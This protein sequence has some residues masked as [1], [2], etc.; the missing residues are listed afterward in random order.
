M[1]RPE[2]AQLSSENTSHYRFIL[3]AP[4]PVELPLGL[5]KGNLIFA[6][7]DRCAFVNPMFGSHLDG[8][9]SCSNFQA[10]S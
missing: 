6:L 3:R 2:D 8:P 5:R 4:I 10:V 9:Q 7:A 1:S